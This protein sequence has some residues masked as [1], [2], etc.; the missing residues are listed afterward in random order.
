LALESGR[1]VLIVP[2]MGSHHPIPK[3]IVVG[4][5]DKREATRAVFDALPLLQRADNVTVIEVD[6][7]PGPETAE[8]RSALCATL[9]LH[10]VTCETDTTRSR[11]GDVGDALLACCERMKADLLV[12]GCYGHSR[13]REF[14]LEGAS[15]HLLQG[16][17]LPVLMSQ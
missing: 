4:F 7:R 8:I 16:M 11:H 9:S 2:N 5:T 10:G 1:P 6:P 15:R 17:T 14:V 3:R 12:M 13:L